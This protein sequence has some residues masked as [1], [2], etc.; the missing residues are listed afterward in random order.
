MGIVWSC[1]KYLLQEQRSANRITRFDV[2]AVIPVTGTA[3]VVYY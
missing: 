2:E 3:E 1:Y